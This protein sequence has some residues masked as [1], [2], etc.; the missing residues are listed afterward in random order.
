M[1]KDSYKTLKKAGRAE[2]IEKKSRFIGLAAPAETEEDA[3]ALLQ[4]ARAEHKDASHNVYAW[5][6]GINGENPRQ[7]DDG[8][9]G[10][11]AGA[12]AL[13]AIS[14][15]GVTN[16]IVIVT[17]YFGGILLGTGGLT[18]A[19]GQ[20]ARESLADAG[21]AE[22]FSYDEFLLT[23]SYP[24]LS[25]FQHEFAKRGYTIKNPV[26]T[27]DVKLGVFVRTPQADEFSRLSADLSG[28]GAHIEFK[29][30]VYL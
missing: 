28:G 29:S 17:R 24:L 10:G 21:I 16:A 4:A 7:S 30:T 13:G 26:Y 5:I 22:R 8:E 6:L 19:Y 25:K 11:T 3:Q 14:K 15:L 23:I 1:M 27:E 18:R 20:A 9:P 2:I 12:P